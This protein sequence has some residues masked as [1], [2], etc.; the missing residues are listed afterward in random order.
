MKSCFSSFFPPWLD[1]PSGPSLLIVEVSISHSDTPKSVRLLWF[2]P[3]QRPVPYNTN[4]QKRQPSTPSAGFETAN[5]A[6][7][8]QQTHTLDRAATGIGLFPVLSTIF[9][10]SLLYQYLSYSSFIPLFSVKAQGLT[11]TTST[12]LKLNRFSVWRSLG[13]ASTTNLQ[14][15]SNL[16]Q[17]ITVCPARSGTRSK[18]HCW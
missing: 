6:S 5:P 14:T 18:L 7:K 12:N 4:I 15:Q 11:P 16:G 9:L 10:Y 8:R 13:K 17:R 2:G 1:I 3:S